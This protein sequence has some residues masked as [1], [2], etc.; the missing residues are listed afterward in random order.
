VPLVYVENYLPQLERDILQINDAITQPMPDLV[1][2][3]LD[4]ELQKLVRMR[5]V[6]LGGDEKSV[7]HSLRAKLRY[8][9]QRSKGER[10]RAK[11]KE[12]EREEKN[13]EAEIARQV[14]VEGSKG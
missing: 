7:L 3:A 14:K 5:D 11:R 10:D 6:L 13:L 2:H 4:G 12:L 1:R 8:A 9:R